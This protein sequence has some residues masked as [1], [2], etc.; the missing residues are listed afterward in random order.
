LGGPGTI[1]I[2]L[3]VTDANGCTASSTTTYT[4]VG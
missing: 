2:K 1:N 3:T 4:R